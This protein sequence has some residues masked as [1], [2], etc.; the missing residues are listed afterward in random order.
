MQAMKT[1]TRVAKRIALGVGLCLA[2]G[3]TAV[4]V[5]LRPTGPE[6]HGIGMALVLEKQEE[7]RR[8]LIKEG[9][10]LNDLEPWQILEEVSRRAGLSQAGVK[11]LVKRARNARDAEL[12]IDALL[13][14]GDAETAAALAQQRADALMKTNPRKAAGVFRQAADG[15]WRMALF[16]EAS[17]CLRK[18]GEEAQMDLAMLHWGQ[19][20][21]HPEDVRAELDAA[22]EAVSKVLVRLDRKINSVD[23]AVAK[24][25]QGNVHV[26][27]ALLMKTATGE[28]DQVR[29]REGE[30]FLREAMDSVDRTDEPQL[31][32]ATLHD[33]AVVLLEQS[34]T[35]SRPLLPQKEVVALLAKALEVRSGK[36]GD[37]LMK[38]DT[39]AM[40]L[41]QRAETLA[42]Q[43]LA[44]ARLAE[45]KSPAGLE[46]TTADQAVAVAE[47]ALALSQPQDPGVSWFV[48]HYAKLRTM[49][50]LSVNTPPGENDKMVAPDWISAFE[51]T[52]QHYPAQFENHPGIPSRREVMNLARLIIPLS[53]AL[54]PESA[55]RMATR[56]LDILTPLA[57]TGTLPGNGN[58]GTAADLL[59][60]WKSVKDHPIYINGVKITIEPEPDYR[61]AAE[62]FNETE[63]PPVSGWRFPFPPGRLWQGQMDRARQTLERYGK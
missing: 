20:N 32:A 57:N 12:K 41:T 44:L 63:R 47:S 18:A 60:S 24:R 8:D 33:L 55:V 35:D 27:L 2:L 4:L 59:E 34:V 14:A 23:V 16:K 56:M 38:A 30:R 17:E 22:N 6:R 21:F 3:I 51:K 52:L 62:I 1:E 29:L 31:W 39:L 26:R 11:G 54:G 15:Y 61:P 40:Q 36:V 45:A 7:Y 19:A 43:S 13:L 58:W 28:T 25:L 49:L 10:H 53:G 9:R 5:W 46:K 48:A 50:N 42:F 37:G